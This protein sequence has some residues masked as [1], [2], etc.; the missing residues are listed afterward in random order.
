M[1]DI[2][3]ND[4][5]EEILHELKQNVYVQEYLPDL[6]VK[7]LHVLH[8]AMNKTLLNFLYGKTFPSIVHFKDFVLLAKP[9]SHHFNLKPS[10]SDKK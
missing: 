3:I 10:V 9:F 8:F 5:D 7:D 6:T 1:I 2:Y 4:F